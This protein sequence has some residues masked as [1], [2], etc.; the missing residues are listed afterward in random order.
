MPRQ[1]GAM[2]QQGDSDLPGGSRPRSHVAR[3]AA[4]S[5][6]AVTVASVTAAA[7]TTN[8]MNVP[9]FTVRRGSRPEP[10]ASGS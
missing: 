10:P 6:A 5:A 1:P 9:E 2:K 7:R 3:S 4:P 8:G